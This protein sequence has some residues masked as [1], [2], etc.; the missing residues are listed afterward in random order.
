VVVDELQHTYPGSTG[1]PVPTPVA[2][3]MSADPVRPLHGRCKYKGLR[4]LVFYMRQ[5][6]VGNSLHTRGSR[7]GHQRHVRL[8][9]CRWQ[10][11]KMSTKVPSSPYGSKRRMCCWLCI[12]V[13]GLRHLAFVMP[14]PRIPFLLSSWLTSELPGY[15]WKVSY[16][17]RYCYNTL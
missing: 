17:T 8:R 13:H 3:A 15:C 4:G 1:T 2:G 16:S 12:G 10:D 11:G 6:F 5:R 9:V 7:T 14:P